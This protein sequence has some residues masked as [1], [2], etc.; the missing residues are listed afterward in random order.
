MTESVSVIIPCRNERSH[1]GRCLESELQTS[2]PIDALEILVVD[3]MSTDG[4][5]EIVADFSRRHSAVRLIENTARIT[6]IAMNLGIKASSGAL[7]V[8]LDA[9]SEYP[10]NYIAGCVEW[11]RQ[12]GADVVGGAIETVPNGDGVVSRAVALVTSHRFGVGNSSFRTATLGGYVDTVPFG[13]YRRDV[14]ERVGLFDERLVRNQ[15]N[16][17]SSRIVKAGGRIYLVPDLRVR[18]FNQSTIRGLLRQAFTTGS[19]NVVTVRINRSAFRW[20]HFAP[21]VFFTGLVGLALG[22]LRYAP[23]AWVAAVVFGGYLLAAAIASA[24]I[25]WRARFAWAWLLPP[26]F[27][28]YHMAYAAGTWAGLLSQTVDR[29]Q[30]PERKTL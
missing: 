5:R 29:V 17:L 21:M 14:F 10:P 24:D 26:I 11:L 6:P 19:W 25:G 15:D 3:G 7:I 30:K 12:T 20:R 2:H 18:Y 8:R 9:H 1:I 22:G 4:T 23:A 13:M 16:E 27:M 28:S